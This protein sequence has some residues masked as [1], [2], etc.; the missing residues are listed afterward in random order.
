MC[1][2]VSLVY[3][4][5]KHTGGRMKMAS[6]PSSKPAV[7]EVQAP[8]P[9]LLSDGMV[10][11][12]VPS[13]PALPDPCEDIDAKE[14]RA[15]RPEVQRSRLCENGAENTLVNA[16][17]SKRFCQNRAIVMPQTTPGTRAGR[18]PRSACPRASPGRRARCP[19]GNTLACPPCRRSPPRRADPRRR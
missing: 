9:L 13:V 11:A 3:L 8:P 15:A 16:P 4:H 12:V 7:G 1:T 17:C 18:T 14:G 10:P 6:A 2:P 5:S 19:A